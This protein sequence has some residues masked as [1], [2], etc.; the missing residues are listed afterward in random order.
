MGREERVIARAAGGGVGR[1][2]A[3]KLLVKACFIHRLRDS[4]ES[5]FATA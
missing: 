3:E 4:Q 2:E 1:E 5:I